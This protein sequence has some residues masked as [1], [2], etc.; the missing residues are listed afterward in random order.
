ML[1][2]ENLAGLTNV[3]AAR[4]N[5]GLADTAT[6]AS[7]NFLWRGNN[8]ADLTNV[9][10]ARNNLG[11]GSAATVNIYGAGA[12][13]FT[14]SLGT[15]GWTRLPNGLLMQWGNQAHGNIVTIS[16]FLVTFPVPFTQVFTCNA[17]EGGQQACSIN[18]MNLN[19]NNFIARIWESNG[20]TIDGI[21]RWWAI[22]V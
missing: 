4:G 8:L 2:S 14:A 22:G 12:L 3:A 9:G 17:T 19:N 5:L 16:D 6:I 7:G 21:I 13:D 10:A 11:L 1:K 20:V 18:T 15:T